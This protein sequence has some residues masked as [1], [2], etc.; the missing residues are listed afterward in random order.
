MKIFIDK[1]ITGSD[2]LNKLIEDSISSTVRFSASYDKQTIRKTPPDTFGRNTAVN[3]RLSDGGGTNID[4]VAFYK[5]PSISVVPE[6]RIDPEE[7]LPVYQYDGETKYLYDQSKLGEFVAPLVSNR[8]NSPADSFRIEN[9]VTSNWV[10][11]VIKFDI[12][13]YELSEVIIGK[14]FGFLNCPPSKHTI[15]DKAKEYGL[16]APE[17][18]RTGLQQPLRP[19]D[20]D[21]FFFSTNVTSLANMN[22]GNK[23]KEIHNKEISAYIS[24]EL[25][26]ELRDDLIVSDPIQN[27]DDT[28][29]VGV[30]IKNSTDYQFFGR[31]IT[32]QFDPNKDFAVSNRADDKWD[33]NNQGKVMYNA[34]L[35]KIV[36]YAHKG[37]SSDDV[38]LEESKSILDTL[39]QQLFGYYGLPIDTVVTQKDFTSNFPEKGKP[40]KTFTFSYKGSAVV[41]NGDYTI[42]LIYEKVNKCPRLNVYKLMDGYNSIGILEGIQDGW[43]S[44]GVEWWEIDSGRVTDKSGNVIRTPEKWKETEDHWYHPVPGDGDAKSGHWFKESEKGGGPSDVRRTENKDGEKKEGD[45]EKLPTDGKYQ[46]TDLNT[47]GDPHLPGYKL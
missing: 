21:T 25:R 31:Y 12:V 38:T 39:C 23:D 22:S 41:L 19:I 16:W 9:I 37:F 44:D 8:L 24:K 46:Y 6:G 18:F 34:G 5:R 36:F 4:A 28:S 20:H 15:Y 2:N 43:S 17:H 42:H 11:G 33:E 14:T 35:N 40:V 10:K 7:N 1:E 27:T 47:F 32:K 29:T 13:A 26:D 45:Y 3:V 30:K